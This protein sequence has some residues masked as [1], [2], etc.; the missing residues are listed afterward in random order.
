MSV[1]MSCPWNRAS[2]SLLTLLLMVGPMYPASANDSLDTLDTL[3]VHGFLS[4]ALVITDENNF[5]GPSSQD[6]GSLQFTEIGANVSLRPHRNVL[7]AAQVLSRRAGG[8]LSDMRPKLDHGVVDYQAFADSTTRLGTQIGRFKNPFGFYNQTRDIAFTRP[9]ILLPQSIYFDRTRSLGLAADGMAIYGEKRLPVGTFRAQ[10]GAG[11]PQVGDD[12]ARALMLDSRPGELDSDTSFIGQLLYEHGGGRFTAALSAADVNATF[13]SHQAAWDGGKLRFQPWI[14][15][16]QYDEE[17]WSLTAE[18]A[19]RHIS[20]SDFALPG[21][22]FDTTGESWYL[23]YTRRFHRDWQWLLR[24]DV[25]VNDRDDRSGRRFEASG[26][27]P[28][29]SRFARDLTLGLRWYVH[30]RLLLATEYHYVEGTGWLPSQDNP[31]SDTQKYW[32]ML[33]FQASWRF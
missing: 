2:T 32:N 14:L 16:L 15:S 4:Q 30:P 31:D 25:L 24:Y 3:Q 18:Y 9:S 23:Q 10:I 1:S 5:F 17:R 28:A 11:K 8:E 7:L 13:Q 21:V 26:A 29:H 6:G 22:N 12:V 20:L 19:L 27:G 33:L